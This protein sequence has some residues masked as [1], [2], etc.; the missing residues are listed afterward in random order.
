MGTKS[1]RCN[2]RLEMKKPVVSGEAH[3]INTE[4]SLSGLMF[5]RTTN[6]IPPRVR[7]P[8]MSSAMQQK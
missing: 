2:C 8:E 7:H 1:R 6:Q 4:G 3:L 5:G